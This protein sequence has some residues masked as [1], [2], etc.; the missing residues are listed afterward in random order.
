MRVE[1]FLAE[2]GL[3]QN[4][5][6]AEEARHDPVFERLIDSD[7]GH[8]DFPKILGRL[9][10]PTTSVVFG[11]KGSGK[12]AIRLQIGRRLE[13]HNAEH[14][15]QR[16]LL[17]AYD[18]LN[19]VLDRVLSAVSRRGRLGG[20]SES[21]E[22]LLESI[23]LE[24][25]QDAMLSLAVTRVVDDLVEANERAVSSGSPSGAGP[26]PQAPRFKNVS[27]RTRVDLAVLAALYDQPA[28]GDVLRR[29]SRLCA[30]LRLHHLPVVPLQRMAAIVMTLAGAGLL[31]LGLAV[32]DM[33][34]WVVPLGAVCAA[35]GVLLWALWAGRHLSV[36]KLVR[37]IQ[38]EMPAIERSNADMRA[39]LLRLGPRVLARQSMPL[40]G[41]EGRTSRYELTDQFLDAMAPLGYGGITILVDRVDEPTLVSGNAERM[42]LLIWPMLDNK[43]LQQ[44]RV[45]FKLL[46]PIELRHLLLRES[47]QFFQEARL[48]KQNLID[49]LVWSGATLYDLCSRRLEACRSASSSGDGQ[50]D[51]RGLMDLF[52]Q[53][54][55]RDLIVDALDA[56]QQ[57][58]DA[59]KFLYSVILDHCRVV[60]DDQPVYQIPR[61]TVEAVRRQHAQRV[62]DFQRGLGPG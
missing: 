6:E 30:K 59:F 38:R 27:R 21:T 33:S 41:H 23:R 34:A 16:M 12:T 25:H 37:K 24:D 10:R 5:F 53:D 61:L 32:S 2:H 56:M 42:R 57:P 15:Q 60:A 48:D 49:R 3:S 8:P 7:T 22:T 29:W 17:V 1:H 46:L 20:R 13:A 4:P 14:P 40:S 35:A 50:Q 52:A 43:F 31:L 26:R 58:R 36:W 44:D 51:G 54:V 19:P 39:M 55:S 45:G 47:S 62:Q 28:S 18:D 11:E 9:D